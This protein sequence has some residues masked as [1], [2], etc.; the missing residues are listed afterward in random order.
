MFDMQANSFLS[1]FILEADNGSLC[2]I[3]SSTMSLSSNSES[4]S[5]A[6]SIELTVTISYFAVFCNGTFL[7]ETTLLFLVSKIDTPKS[8][9]PTVS[10][11]IAPE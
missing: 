7:T 9:W 4:F 6:S 10:F 1:D 11:V 2:T 8:F 3:S 5:S